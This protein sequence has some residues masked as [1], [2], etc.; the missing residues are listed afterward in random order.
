M[1]KWLLL[2]VVLCVACVPSEG[3]PVKGEGKTTQTAQAKQTSKAIKKIESL[4]VLRLPKK[5]VRIQEQSTFENRR[6]IAV[7]VEE[8]IR[9]K[10]ITSD[11]MILAM[12][13]NAWHESKW[14]P[15]TA[16]KSCIG[17]FQLHIKYMGRGSTVSQL[18]NLEHNVQKLM[19]TTSFKDWVAWCKKYPNKS[20]GDFSLK[21]ASHVERC[22]VKHR[23]PR[24]I[25]ADKWYQMLS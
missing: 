21:F 2:W 24:K 7:K 12:L 17:F 20:C 9:K 16:S 15:S 14:N 22:A 10:G 8:M 23:Y 18:K 1:L 13:A 19:A 6:K 25:T 4:T 11:K 5:A 3:N